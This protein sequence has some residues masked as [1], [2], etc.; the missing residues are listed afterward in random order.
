MEGA[1]QAPTSSTVNTAFGST[2]ATATPNISAVRT[3]TAEPDGMDRTENMIMETDTTMVQTTTPWTRISEPGEDLPHSS[4]LQKSVTARTSSSA[5]PVSSLPSSANPSSHPSSSRPFSYAQVTNRTTS[6]PSSSSP[7]T[8]SSSFKLTE[9][10]RQQR[11]QILRRTAYGTTTND[12][13]QTVTAQ[14]GVPE[15]QLFEC[16]I[17]DPDDHRRFYVTYRTQQM[18]TRTTGKGYYI[19]DLHI[20][21]TD[22]YLTG[23]IPHPPPPYYIDRQTLDDLLSS[24][25]TVK[26][27]SFVSTPRNTRIGG[28]K[29]KLKL[30]TDVGRPTSLLYNGVNMVIRYQDDVKQ[31]AY[32]KRYGHIISACRTKKTADADRQRA[33]DTQQEEDRANWKREHHLL[34]TAIEDAVLL[35]QSNYAT[36]KRQLEIV[37]DQVRIDLC[38]Q[39]TSDAN[40][41]IWDAVCE[42]ESDTIHNGFT[43]EIA[44]LYETS[45]DQQSAL[46]QAYT[47]RGIT[48]DLP[49]PAPTDIDA[50][51]ATIPASE[52]SP[53]DQSDIDALS[54]ELLYIYSIKVP[55]IDATEI[56]PQMQPSFSHHHHVTT[57]SDA[58]RIAKEQRERTRLSAEKDRLAAKSREEHRV[59]EQQ[60]IQAKHVQKEKARQAAIYANKKWNLPWPPKKKSRTANAR[61]W[62]SWRTKNHLPT[63]QTLV[64]V[65]LRRSY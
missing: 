41:L 13:L 49:P 60:R 47:K 11:T 25:G 33:R 22:D 45:N 2:T 63:N 17:R 23:Y 15:E 12:I 7:P 20:R 4:C 38:T 18:K 53:T 44:A 40:M 16:V 29:F 36:A 3:R 56:S 6:P 64:E 8:S 28:Y 54:S 62:R 58:D 34:Q 32:C 1:F 26:E 39:K 14:M 30:K 46:S 31:C 24:F 9:T 21:P 57:N 65:T 19:G 48:V 43:M 59:K 42:R 10:R 50:L 61:K 55:T 51:L 35:V 37:Y 27:A 52:P 5:P